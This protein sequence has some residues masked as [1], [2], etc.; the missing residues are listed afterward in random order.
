[1]LR[2]KGAEAAADGPSEVRAKSGEARAKP[3][4]IPWEFWSPAKGTG[5]VGQEFRRGKGVP[6]GVPRVPHHRGGGRDRADRDR[7]A[8]PASR[9][10]PAAHLPVLRRGPSLLRPV[11]PPLRAAAVIARACQVIGRDML[12]S[13]VRHVPRT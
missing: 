3:V 11:L 6:D 8:D 2:W 7:I 10:E 13:L 1:M 9:L 12:G 4:R 5:F